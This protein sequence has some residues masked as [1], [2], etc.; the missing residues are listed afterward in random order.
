MAGGTHSP[1]SG[2]RWERPGARGRGIYHRPR[3][4]IPPTTVC[5]GVALLNRRPGGGHWA[6]RGTG[7][8]PPTFWLSAGRQAVRG[9]LRPLGFRPFG[10]KSRA[11][12]S[13]GTGKPKGRVKPDLSRKKGRRTG[14]GGRVPPPLLMCAARADGDTG[15]SG[16][17]HRPLGD[18]HSGEG[19][20]I[21]RGPRA[22]GVNPTPVGAAEYSLH[23][24]GG[25]GG[26]GPRGRF[27]RRWVVGG[28]PF[29]V[30]VGGARVPPAA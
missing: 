19:P 12:G 16:N 3:G 30:G 25:L 2:C 18:R 5:V 21:F 13:A 26:S 10:D 17:P 9:Q 7:S 15:A 6:L 8:G 11:R 28:T 27:L 29:F 23:G 20:V 24:W 14:T 1:S 22:S 4:R